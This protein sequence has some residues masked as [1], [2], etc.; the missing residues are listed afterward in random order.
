MIKL[1][2]FGI[3]RVCYFIFYNILRSA[4]FLPSLQADFDKFSAIS[5]LPIG[6]VDGV[7]ASDASTFQEKVSCKTKGLPGVSIE[8]MQ[9]RLLSRVCFVLW[10]GTL[11]VSPFV[12]K[13]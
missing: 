6:R 9:V 13:C 12:V 11:R 3:W 2:N 1:F 8:A 10:H 4:S 5:Y 7:D